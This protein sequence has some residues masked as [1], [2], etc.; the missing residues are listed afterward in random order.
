MEIREYHTWDLGIQE[1]R[2]IQN[3]L[4]KRLILEGG[5][6]NVNLIAGADVSYTKG[7]G[8]VWAGVIVFDLLKWKV[9]EE[10]GEYGETNFPYIPGYLSFREIPVLLKAFKKV[11]T[12]PDVVLLDGQ[13]IAH[14][15]RMGIASHIGIFL[16]VP[17]VGCAKNRLVGDFTPVGNEKGA[18]SPLM[19]EGERVGWVL[20]TREG[21]KPVFVSPGHRIGF[22]RAIEIIQESCGR[23][24]L[25][26]PIRRAH[27][28]ANWLRRGNI[29]T[30]MN[31]DN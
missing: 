9:V 12:F 26:E 17:T 3:A 14:P 31:I 29:T 6:K 27:N 19:I 20:R 24:R 15:R 7:N 1:A 11:Q 8:A 25:P 21:V 28:L 5:P 18:R 30:H 13:G 4:L 16:D 2:E 10:R 23:Y 22:D